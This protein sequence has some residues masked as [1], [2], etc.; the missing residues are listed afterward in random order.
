MPSFL[1]KI[2]FVDILGE[3]VTIDSEV[4]TTMEF[5]KVIGN[6]VKAVFNI[7]SAGT[8][9]TLNF[10]DKTVIDWG[11]GTINNDTLSHEYT[12]VGNYTC[13]I[14]GIT[15]IGIS[16]FQNCR[17]LTSVTIPDSVTSIGVSAFKNCTALTSITIP[18]SVTSVGEGAFNGCSS[19]E[20]ITIPFVGGSKKTAT[21]TYQYPFGY[22]FGT[23]QYTGGTAT[24][25][26]YYGSSTSS[27]TSSTYY[28]PSSLKSVTV[29]G[30]EILY[31]AFYNC[32]ALTSI[33]IP[34]SVTNIGDDAFFN[35]NAL[36]S[37]TIPDSV[38]SIGSSAFY[39]CSGLTSVIIGNGVTN[40]GSSA[41]FNC[42]GLT[43][44]TIP[45]SVTTIGV[46]AF[47]S[48]GSLK[49]VIIDNGVKYIYS[50]AFYNCNKLVSI[51][52]PDS[53]IYIADYAFDGCSLLTIYF[54]GTSTPDDWDPD[55]NPLD[56]PIYYECKNIDLSKYTVIKT[57]NSEVQ[58]A[59]GII[60]ITIKSSSN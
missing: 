38:I 47:Q 43:R 32:T 10:E 49:S 48:C 25:Q 5:D 57:S 21:D 18:D 1:D 55:F 54:E 42:S 33:I 2:R 50:Y 20:S 44:I 46:R 34:N 14:Y 11:D 27:T 56:R 12:T 30:G 29:T 9:I 23:S 15:N 51:T 17:R 53:V 22:I 37:V 4:M 8:S 39:Y 40:I 16:A 35:C 19:L 24:I 3:L 28:I 52:I 41:F 59:N 60:I 31:G 36:A 26:Q 7:T 13:Y 45:G 6:C 58:G